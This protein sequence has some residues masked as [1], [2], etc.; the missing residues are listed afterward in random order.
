[1]RSR[2]VVSFVVSAAC[3]PA[4]LGKYVLAIECDGATYHSSYTARDRDRLRQQQLLRSLAGR[5]T[6]SGRPTGSFAARKRLTEPCRP[7]TRQ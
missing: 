5:S 7:F 1:M 2:A 6:E 4:A 3:H